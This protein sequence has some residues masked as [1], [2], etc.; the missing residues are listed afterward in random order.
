M[1]H[2]GGRRIA[3]ALVV[4]TLAL[5]LGVSASAPAASSDPAGDQRRAR[6][7]V[8]AWIVTWDK[9][10]VLESLRAN[11]DRI[12]QIS[13]YWFELKEDGSAVVTREGAGDRDVLA[14][15]RE[16]GIRVVPTVTNDLD[17]TR[18]SA[19]LATAAARRRHV[20]Q[21]VR[22]VNRPAYAGLDLDYE[23]LEPAD[24]EEF[25]AFVR[26]L[27]AALHAR[28]KTLTVSVQPTTASDGQGSVARSLDYSAIGR[29]ADEV[30][31]LAYDRNW[32]CGGSGPVAPI[33]WVEDV[34]KF[35]ERR[36]PRRKIV[37]GV[38]L[39][40]YDWPREGCAVSR[41]W[42]DVT[43]QRT[44]YDGRLA[45]SARWQ[46][47]QMRY[48]AGT[49][50]RVVWFEDAAGTKA[51]AKLVEEHRLRGVALWRIGGEDPATWNTLLS[52]LGP[53]RT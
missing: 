33:D 44:L 34:V 36:V 14:I 45:W 42:R 13:P 30:R 7:K 5:V 9:V 8:E 3:V 17:A 49:R 21:L 27:A 4:A 1:M 47:R 37:L 20:A 26:S 35:V 6:A 18:V 15:A 39:Y 50:A 22:I 10:R 29:V 23:H 19:S 41:T 53:A 48:G 38:P 2:A 24:R 11:K 43:R 16:A 31:V 40:G 32:A 46:A 52:V 28:D 25:V 51:K 12:G